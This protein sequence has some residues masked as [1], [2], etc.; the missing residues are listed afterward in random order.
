MRQHRSLSEHERAIVERMLSLDFPDVDYFRRQV[1]AI[2]VTSKCSCGCGT[3]G[4]SIGPEAPRA[5]SRT[6]DGHTGPI[7]ESHGGNW[8]MLFQVDGV[9]T[10]LEHVTS[11]GPDLRVV[12]PNKLEL[13]LVVED[14]WFT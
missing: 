1:S 6:W 11:G 8:L 10:E 5:P 2:T 4:F 3:I 14:D 7:V 13:D 12:D 9:L